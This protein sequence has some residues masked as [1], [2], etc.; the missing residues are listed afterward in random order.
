MS[1]PRPLPLRVRFAL[2]ESPISLLV[3]LAARAGRRDVAAFARDFGL[4]VLDVARGMA[5]ERLAEFA[6]FE[7][8]NVERSSPEQLSQKEFLF[9]GE[10]LKLAFH[11]KG[12][13]GRQDHRRFCAGCIQS[14]LAEGRQI[15]S[16]PKQCAYVRNWWNV[17]LVRTCPQHLLL[18]SDACLHCRSPIGDL[19]WP[20][21]LCP[22]C[23]RQVL[24]DPTHMVPESSVEADRYLLGRLGVMETMSVPFLD[25]L[26]LSDASELIWRLGL[27]RIALEGSALPLS[28]RSAS[29]TAHAASIGLGICRRG[30]DGIRDLFGEM[31]DERPKGSIS[32]PSHVYGSLYVWLS[33]PDDHVDGVKGHVALLRTMLR[34]H[35]MSEVPMMT[36]DDLFGEKASGSR[37]TTV[38]AAANHIALNQ[39][40]FTKRATSLGL[41]SDRDRRLHRFER[42]S[43]AIVG[44][45]RAGSVALKDVGP[46]LGISYKLASRIVRSGVIPIEGSLSIGARLFVSEEILKDFRTRCGMHRPVVELPG[47]RFATIGSRRIDTLSALVAIHEGRMDTLGPTR[48]GDLLSLAVDLTIAE[49]KGFRIGTDGRVRIDPLADCFNDGTR[50]RYSRRLKGTEKALAIATGGTLLPVRDVRRDLKVRADVLTAIVRT[51]LLSLGTTPCGTRTGIEA[52]SVEQFRR[53]Y[54]VS[55]AM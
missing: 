27:A 38:R 15:G 3:R 54:V 22:T 36:D 18:L 12:V 35:A 29:I 45:S 42:S 24:P 32:E 7:F 33:R 43:I 25:A 16:S 2:G 30:A 51:G 6:R 31:L 28:K 48:S 55:S 47:R 37:Y 41:F 8:A 39:K 21:E 10:A 5:D 17:M 11:W 13:G 49:A 9:G 34:D 4:D 20:M 1:H 23:S 40:T 44:T 26:P 50:E 19:S 53:R 46:R 52:E 14:D